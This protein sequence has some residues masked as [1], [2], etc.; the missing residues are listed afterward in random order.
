MNKKL[1]GSQTAKGGFANEHSIVAKFNNWLNDNE[2]QIWLQIMGYNLSSISNINAIQIPTK[3]KKT[4]VEKYQI[5]EEDYEKFVK[6][7]KADIQ[8]KLFIEV[9]GILKIENISLKKANANAGFNQIDKR[10]VD[11]YQIMWNFDNEIALW[12]KLFTGELLAKNHKNLF[13]NYENLE[14]PDKRI[15]ANEMP[16][17]IQ[18]KIIDFFEK[19]KTLILMDTLKGRGGLSASWMLVTQMNEDNTS[20]WILKDINVTI[21]FYAQGETK[22]S[23][24]GSF[25]IGKIT[26]Q[27]KGGTPDPTKLQF[28][29]NPCDLFD[30]NKSN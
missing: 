12:L 24:R 3:I 22:I 21:N 15:F 19:N 26:L 2:A 16:L 7:K 27:R 11:D 14:E 13:E 6:F 18:K 23:P 9:E 29:F 28:K 17:K 25:Q 10:K 1:L 30:L 8:I 20:F 4:E 5:S